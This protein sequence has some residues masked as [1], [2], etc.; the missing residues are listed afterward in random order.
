VL[1]VS[2][3]RKRWPRFHRWLG[4]ATGAVVLTCVIPSG[5]YLAL[6]AQGGLWSTLGFWLTGAI[7]CLAM[8][9]GIRS[10]RT[11]DMRAH[12]RY[13]SHVAAQLSVAVVSR[14][15]L[16]GAE[17]LGL[18]GEW[19]YIASLWVPVLG[20]A[21]V[22]ELVTAPRRFSFAKGSRHETLVAVPRLDPVR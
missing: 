22:A 16:M 9:A 1:T 5:A 19:A 14:L 21:L 8:V 10:A 13:S 17:A 6:F 12:R 15:M 7:T 2:W 11:G 3:I 18:Y 4:R 20:C